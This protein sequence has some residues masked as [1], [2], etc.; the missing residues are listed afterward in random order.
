MNI[1]VDISDNEVE[2]E[3]VEDSEEEGDKEDDEEDNDGRDSL[4]SDIAEVEYDYDEE[5]YEDEEESEPRSLPT[6]PI[7]RIV[8]FVSNVNA[9][10]QDELSVLGRNIRIALALLTFFTPE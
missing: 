8:T 5:L 7:G 1:L 10:I 3:E 4:Y 9:R 6:D 2:D